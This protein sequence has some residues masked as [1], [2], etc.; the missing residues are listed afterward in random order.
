MIIGPCTN[1]AQVN[2]GP[3]WQSRGFIGDDKQGQVHDWRAQ[4]SRTQS[5][6]HIYKLVTFEKY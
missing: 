1:M 6:E 3:Y 5:L 4:K 2:I